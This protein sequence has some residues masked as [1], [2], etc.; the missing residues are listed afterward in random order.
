V[1]FDPSSDYP[2]GSRR[3]DLVSTPAGT[4]LAELTFDALRA[5]RISAHELRATPE[6]LRRQAQIALAAGRRPLAG[7][8][9]RAAE[10]ASVPDE[11]I[12]EVYTALRPHRSTAEELQGWANRL[13]A[14]HGAPLTA[15]FVRDAC[16]VYAERGLLAPRGERATV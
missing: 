1:D 13:E 4:P 2:L 12:L 14:E 9:A 10:L 6:T 15:E 3:P 5:G 16:A 8:L 7:N 11:V